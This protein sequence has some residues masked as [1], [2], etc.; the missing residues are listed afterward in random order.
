MLLVLSMQQASNH[1]C[2]TCL[3]FRS[4]EPDRTGVA[5]NSL[6]NLGCLERRRRAMRT[7]CMRLN[8]M[9]GIHTPIKLSSLS[10]SPIPSSSCRRRLK[11]GLSVISKGRQPLADYRI[12]DHGSRV[13]DTKVSWSRLA[14]LKAWLKTRARLFSKF[15]FKVCRLLC[16]CIEASLPTSRGMRRSK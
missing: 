8:K 14:M 15:P 7:P 5:F 3:R 2:S 16:A 11:H 12:Q 6:Y 9:S 13:P 10:S 4:H 1:E